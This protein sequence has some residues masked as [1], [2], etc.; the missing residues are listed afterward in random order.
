[1]G[2]SYVQKK[3]QQKWFP[4]WLIKLMS[5]SVLQAVGLNVDMQHMISGVFVY[6]IGKHWRLNIHF[7]KTKISLLG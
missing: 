5:W 3:K 6:C 4:G 7:K 1:M 2:V